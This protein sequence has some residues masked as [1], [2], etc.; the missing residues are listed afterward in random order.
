MNW[1]RL[2][3]EDAHVDAVTPTTFDGIAAQWKALGDAFQATRTPNEWTQR[4]NDALRIV[5]AV[6]GHLEEYRKAVARREEE[7]MSHYLDLLR[8]DRLEW[9][10]LVVRGEMQ[11]P[12][13][14]RH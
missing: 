11:I 6:G 1:T 14:V 4:D 9:E 3:V 12:A 10:S 5:G 7:W 8:R 13:S 2:V